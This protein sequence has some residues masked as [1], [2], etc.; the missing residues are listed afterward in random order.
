MHGAQTEEVSIWAAKAARERLVQRTLLDGDL[1]AHDEAVSGHLA[2][3]GQ[4]AVD[5]LGSIDESDDEREFAAGIDERGG[6]H[7]LAPGEARDRVEDG[8]PGHVLGA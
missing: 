5:V 8:G 2:Q 6:L 4:D 3:L 1:F 7:A